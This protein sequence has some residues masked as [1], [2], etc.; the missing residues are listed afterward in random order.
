MTNDQR[1]ITNARNPTCQLP[2]HFKH[3]TFNFKR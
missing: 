1:L 3:E 2:P